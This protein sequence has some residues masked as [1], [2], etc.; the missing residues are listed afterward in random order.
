MC[1]CLLGGGGGGGGVG[2]VWTAPSRARGGGGTVSRS[3]PA[4]GSLFAWALIDMGAAS[5][6]T[7]AGAIDF[8]HLLG[9]TL[10]TWAQVRLHSFVLTI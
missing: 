1:S 8:L 10:W 6:A 2:T 5:V 7:E 9:K 4:E 3:E